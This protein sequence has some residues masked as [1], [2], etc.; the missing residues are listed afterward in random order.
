MKI[1]ILYR[2]Q[3][4]GENGHESRERG[5]GAPIRLDAEA[6]AHIEKQRYVHY[7]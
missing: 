2:N 1:V 3:E 7:Y 6:Q 4:V 5:T